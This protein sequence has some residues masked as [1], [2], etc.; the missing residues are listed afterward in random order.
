M[1]IILSMLL[2]SMLIKKLAGFTDVNKLHLGCL[3]LGFARRVYINE[4]TAGMQEA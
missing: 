1:V 3:H 2:D 4:W